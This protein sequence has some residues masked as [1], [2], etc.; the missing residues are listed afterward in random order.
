M[1][2]KPLIIVNFKLYSR[3]RVLFT[4]PR[5]SNAQNKIDSKIHLPF[6]RNND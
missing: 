6:Y 5:S 4:K 1:Q 2:L 3:L